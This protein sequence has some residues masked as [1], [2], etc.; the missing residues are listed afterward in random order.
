MR[1]SKLLSAVALLIIIAAISAGC[2]GPGQSPPPEIGQ[3]SNYTVTSTAIPD[4][5]D[6]S[7]SQIENGLKPGDEVNSTDV[8]GRNYFWCEYKDNITSEMPPNGVVQSF[9]FSRIERSIGEYNGTPAIHYRSVSK[10]ENWEV[11]S[12]Q[13]IDTSVSNQLGGSIVNIKEN[14]IYSTED[15]ALEPLNQENRPFGE[16]IHTY[17]YQGTESVTVPAGT[18]PEA[19]KYIR[20]NS[21]NTVGC[22]Y[23]FEPGIPVPVLYQF[24]NKYITGYNGFESHELMGWGQT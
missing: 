21:D 14:Q 24:S 12:D 11:I 4:T 6:H 15:Y 10:G 20:Y 13:F 9:Y 3:Q 2:S 8:F 18:F 17:V 5:V 19:R 1:R 7:G 16:K 22:T 23:W